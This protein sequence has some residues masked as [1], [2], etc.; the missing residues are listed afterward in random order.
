MQQTSLKALA[1]FSQI[2][3]TDK[4]E[5]FIE[6]DDE[7]HKAN[8]SREYDLGSINLTTIVLIRSPDDFFSDTKDQEHLISSLKGKCCL[9]NE[10][11]LTRG[12]NKMLCPLC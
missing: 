4:F 12:T 8:K 9:Y 10:W 11:H 3:L 5:M 6:N 7:L 2:H 1:H